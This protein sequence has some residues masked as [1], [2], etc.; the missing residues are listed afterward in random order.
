MCN[1]ILLGQKI[2][3]VYLFLNF[4]N[5]HKYFHVLIYPYYS[6]KNTQTIKSS[7][8]QIMGQFLFFVLFIDGLISVHWYPLYIQF[9]WTAAKQKLIYILSHLYFRECKCGVRLSA[10]SRSVRT[11]LCQ[12]LPFSALYR[13]YFVNSADNVIVKETT[14]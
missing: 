3:Y 9:C 12:Q 7:Q 4:Y 1:L 5:E 8:E 6:F 2:K 13:L 10:V 14:V 11:S